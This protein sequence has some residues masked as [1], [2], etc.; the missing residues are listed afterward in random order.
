MTDFY[1]ELVDAGFE[2]VKGRSVPQPPYTEWSIIDVEI[3]FDHIL[4]EL[5]KQAPRVASETRLSVKSIERV[6]LAIA[7]QDSVANPP[8]PPRE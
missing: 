1:H 8:Y 2:P 5:W 3:V 4:S 7:E 6:I